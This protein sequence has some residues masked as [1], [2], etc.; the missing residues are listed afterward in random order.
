MQKEID[1]LGNAVNNPAE[2]VCSNPWWCQSI[3][4]DFCNQE[5]A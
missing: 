1:F 4:Q 2:T 5:P 3:Q